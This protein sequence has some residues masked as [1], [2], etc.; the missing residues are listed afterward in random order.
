[1]L[2]LLHNIQERIH[3]YKSAVWFPVEWNS[4]FTTMLRVRNYYIV[5]SISGITWSFAWLEMVIS[6]FHNRFVS[7]AI[8]NEDVKIIIIYTLWC[9]TRR[10]HHIPGNCK[11]VLILTSSALLYCGRVLSLPGMHLAGRLARGMNFEYIT[12]RWQWSY[13]CKYWGTYNLPTISHE[14]LMRG[15]ITCYPCIKYTKLLNGRRPSSAGKIVL[16]KWVAINM[17]VIL[18]R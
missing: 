5:I 4:V 17:K 10:H 18:W 11:Q 14:N 3:F 13:L 7:P 2:F 15:M 12:I 6:N 1:M 16:F 9:S 8:I